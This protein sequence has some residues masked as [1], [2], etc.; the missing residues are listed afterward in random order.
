M[1]TLRSTKTMTKRKVTVCKKKEKK[2]MELKHIIHPFCLE[3]Q[4]GKG[5]EKELP[6]TTAAT[7]LHLNEYLT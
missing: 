2:E 1:L 5:E 4:M 3:F 6:K 7:L